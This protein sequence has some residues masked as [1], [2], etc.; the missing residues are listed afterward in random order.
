MSNQKDSTVSGTVTMVIVNFDMS[1]PDDRRELTMEDIARLVN[2]C[3]ARSSE[4]V[5]DEDS[6]QALF[7]P[8]PDR[9]LH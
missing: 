3:L 4:A 2:E 9:L 6:T 1:P 7:E 5:I 8:S